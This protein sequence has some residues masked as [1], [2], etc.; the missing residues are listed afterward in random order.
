MA[1]IDLRRPRHFEHPCLFVSQTPVSF[2]STKTPAFILPDLWTP[3][4]LKRE[5]MLSLLGTL[6]R[7][8]LEC[9]RYVTLQLPIMRG[10]CIARR[11][12]Q[13]RADLLNDFH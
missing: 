11:T 2:T 6:K 9:T 8:V 1:V 3:V 12:V 5:M 10:R 13:S 7:D 4:R